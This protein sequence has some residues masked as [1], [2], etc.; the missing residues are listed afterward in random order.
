LIYVFVFTSAWLAAQ[1]LQAQGTEISKALKHVPSSANTLAIVKVQDMLNSPRGKQEQWA[2]KHQSEFLAGAV[3]VP[4]TV[5]YLIRAFE[6]HPEDSRIT[7]SYGVAS[8]KIPVPMTKLAEHERSRVQMVAGHAT[9]QTG[10]DSIFA[11]FS[12]GLVGAIR[13]AYRQDLARWLRESDKGKENSVSPYLQDAFARSDNSHITL[14]LDFQDLVDPQSWR[15]RIKTSTAVSGK[16]NAIK[17]MSDL[18]DSLRG[19]TLRIQVAEK[20]KATV[21]LDFGTTVSQTAVPFVK[22]VFIDLLEEAGASL[23]D[24]E[25]AEVSAEGKTAALNFELSDAGLRHVMSMILMPGAGESSADVPTPPTPDGT[26]QATAAP[27]NEP[28][29][30]SSRTYYTSVNQ[31]LDDLEALAKKGGNYNKTATWHDNYAKKIDDLP[32]RGVDPDLL[33]WGGTVSSNLR[34][35]AV[36]LRGVPIDV[37]M[38]EGGLTYNVQYLPA[39][40]RNNNWS[41]WSTVSWQP[42]Y[43]NVETNQGQIRAEQAKAVAAGAKQRE[44]V[45][46]LLLSDRQQIRVKMQEKFGRDFNSPRK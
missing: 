9:V 12:P 40:Y 28:N 21:F 34:A 39:G 33:T 11:E 13:P 30:N 43:L 42:E 35:L 24:L 23:D 6:F 4:P 36:S 45:W 5:D 37:K 18:A 7:N 27:S 16:T 10:R 41:V 25:N 32:I 22:P 38:L 2:K 3:H 20:T 1:G 15:N 31:I 29:V 19:V 14:A 44:Q 17:L 46:Q 8:F 26:S